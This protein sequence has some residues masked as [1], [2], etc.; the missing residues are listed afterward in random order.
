MS[1]NLTI[2]LLLNINWYKIFILHR[3]LIMIF[4][5]KFI[6][7][8]VYIDMYVPSRHIPINCIISMNK[9]FRLGT[10]G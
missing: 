8:Y 6:Y 3:A 9:Y 7:I 5:D 2:L 10:Y 4:R 1:H